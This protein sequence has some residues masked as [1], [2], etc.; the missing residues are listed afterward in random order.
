MRQEWTTANTRKSVKANI[1]PRDTGLDQSKSKRIEN[2]H[3]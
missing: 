2:L 1:S 3:I